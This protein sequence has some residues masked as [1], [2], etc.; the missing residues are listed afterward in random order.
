MKT[1][2]SVKIKITKARMKQ[3][4]KVKGGATSVASTAVTNLPV[5]SASAGQP[6]TRERSF[7]AMFMA[8]TSASSCV[9]MSVMMSRAFIKCLRAGCLDGN[10]LVMLSI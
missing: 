6:E 4:S 7:S 9:Q 1:A 2:L 3:L 10:C 8:S 5:S